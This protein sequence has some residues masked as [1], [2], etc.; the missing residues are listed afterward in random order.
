MVRDWLIKIREAANMTHEDVA[1]AA[2]IKRQYYSMIE[3][4]KRNPSVAVAQKI[5]E[6]L[7]FDWTIFFASQGNKTFP[8]E[9]SANEVTA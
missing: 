6:I 4:G 9:E 8:I 1:N 2:G 5:A 3:S 7:N